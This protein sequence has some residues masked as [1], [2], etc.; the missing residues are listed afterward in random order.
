MPMSFTSFITDAY[1][2]Y[3]TGIIGGTTDS[4][5]Q[6]LN[7]TITLP[8]PFLATYYQISFNMNFYDTGSLPS[9]KQLAL[10][11]VIIDGNG[12]EYRGNTFNRE[13]P[14][15]NWFQPSQYT[16]TS[17]NPMPIYYSDYFDLSSPIAVNDLQ[18][19]LWWFGDQTN[20]YQITATIQFLTTNRI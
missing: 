9:D 5:V 8:N 18:L 6:V 2:N 17:Q 15:A 11:W 13:T 14:W 20:D 19:Q 1:F 16:N 4:W 3:P 7:Q 12:N 10:Y